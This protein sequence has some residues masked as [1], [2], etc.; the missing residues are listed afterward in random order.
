MEEEKDFI[1]RQ[2]HQVIDNLGR[3]LTKDSLKAYIDYDLA[4]Q[5]ALTEREIDQILLI[6]DLKEVVSRYQISQDTLSRDLSL[7]LDQIEAYYHLEEDLPDPVHAKI[8]A[9]VKNHSD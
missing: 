3:Y 8:Q 1:M 2:I 9:F 7:D 4:S 6:Q 5:S